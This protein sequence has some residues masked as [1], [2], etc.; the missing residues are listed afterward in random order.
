ME[1]SKALAEERHRKLLVVRERGIRESQCC[2][3]H[4]YYR[5]CLKCL[6]HLLISLGLFGFSPAWRRIVR[7]MRARVKRQ[8]FSSPPQ[9]YQ[10]Q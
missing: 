3:Q 9:I 10:Q 6:V 1:V 4:A 5:N 2:Q 8:K 7:A